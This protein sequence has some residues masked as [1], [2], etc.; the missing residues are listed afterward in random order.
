VNQDPLDLISIDP[1]ICHGQPCVKGTRVLVAV[2]LDALV[3][4]R[5][6]E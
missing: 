6:P 2:V 1:L 5:W 3:R 4:I